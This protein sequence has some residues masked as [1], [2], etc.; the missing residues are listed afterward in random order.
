ME[1]RMME[2]ECNRNGEKCRRGLAIV[3]RHTGAY[4]MGAIRLP[5]IQYHACAADD[6]ERT[7]IPIDRFSPILMTSATPHQSLCGICPPTVAC[8]VRSRHLPGD[9]ALP[10][11]HKRT[12]RTQTARSRRIQTHLQIRTRDS[13][14]GSPGTTTRRF[15]RTSSSMDDFLFAHHAFCIMPHSPTLSSCPGN[16]RMASGISTWMSPRRGSRH[17]SRPHV[18]HRTRPHRRSTFRRSQ[19]DG[20]ISERDPWIRHRR[21]VQQPVHALPLEPSARIQEHRGVPGLLPSDFP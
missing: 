2:Q 21:L 13:S 11:H 15:A 17:H 3:L 10:G 19:R 16:G 8:S 14:Q 12:Y 20:L 7:P 4:W 5:F 18:L 1:R 6:L 9:S